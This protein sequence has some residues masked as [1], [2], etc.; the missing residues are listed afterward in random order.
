MFKKSFWGFNE[1]PVFE[2]DRLLLR[3]VL[4]KDKEDMFEYARD[5]EVTK[6]LLWYEHPDVQYTAKYLRYLQP[7]Y[8]RGEYYD[9]AVVNKAQDKMI[10]TCGFVTFDGD[11]N[12]AEIGYVISPK[13]RGMGYAPEAVRRIISFGFEELGLNRIY[14]RHIVGNDPSGRVMQKSG[15]SF[16]GI[17]RSSM[18]IKE[19]YRDIA[20]YA[21]TRE[22]Y[23]KV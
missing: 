10:G 20:L 1:F 8:R 2:T 4:L 13:Y 16:E 6:Y 7:K 23:K 15:M 19:Q 3:K 12:N 5:P 14:A 9:W 18:Y 21:V 17:L 11:H 22:D